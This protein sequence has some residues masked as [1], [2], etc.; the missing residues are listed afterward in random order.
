MANSLILNSQ[1]IE[2]SEILI[3][4]LVHLLLGARGFVLL[5]A[6][7]QDSVNNNSQHLLACSCSVQAGIVTHGLHIDEDV[8]CDI[9]LFEVAIVEGYDVGKVV[10][11]EELDVHRAMSLCRAEDVVHLLDAVVALGA[12]N[13]A[14]P[15]AYESFISQPVVAPVVEIEYIH[16]AWR[17]YLK[18]DDAFILIDGDGA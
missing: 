6:E 9:A 17:G 16:C 8:A 10:V 3:L 1:F 15:L 5:A 7:V 13:L 18:S 4:L 2:Q 11:T 12:C 14:Q